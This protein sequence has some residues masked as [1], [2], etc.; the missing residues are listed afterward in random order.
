[1]TA[2]EYG[3]DFSYWTS[4]TIDKKNIGLDPVVLELNKPT[5][6]SCKRV[7]PIAANFNAH[8]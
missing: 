5:I 3:A 2:T 8:F 1:M 7:K 6:M 4:K